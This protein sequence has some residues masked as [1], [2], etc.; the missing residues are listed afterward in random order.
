M[1]PGFAGGLA[2]GI[3]ADIYVVFFQI[4][5]QAGIALAAAVSSLLVLLGLWFAYP[6]WRRMCAHAES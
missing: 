1:E 6:V 5:G 4:S 3:A 2:L